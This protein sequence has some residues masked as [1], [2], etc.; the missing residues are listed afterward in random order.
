MAARHPEIRARETMSTTGNR[1]SVAIL[2]VIVMV[3]VAPLVAATTL[4][5]GWPGHW[6][7]S[8]NPLTIIAMAFFGLITVPLWPTYI[9][10]IILTPWV[11][12]RLAP[13]Q[14]FRVLPMPILILASLVIG[15]IGGVCV[16]FPVILM[17][18]HEA[19]NPALQWQT[20][21]AVSGAVTLTVISLVYRHL[22]KAVDHTPPPLPLPRNT[23]DTGK[24]HQERHQHD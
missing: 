3:T 9:P 16:M 6:G 20:A 5:C 24:K 14:T 18:L 13:R 12:G 10:A 21:G 15:A 11:M 22:T 1:T 7:G 19:A 2:S 4:V 17:S 8:V 23:T